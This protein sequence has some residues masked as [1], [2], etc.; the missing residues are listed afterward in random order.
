MILPT[1]PPEIKQQAEHQAAHCRVMGNPQR[2]MILWLLVERERTVTEIALAIGASLQ[3]ASHH[4]R[5]LE[6]SN[7]VK[8]RREHH[9]VFY[10][11]INNE[12]VKRCPVLINCPIVETQEVSLI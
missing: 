4:L 1:L 10:H 6:F 12:I 9:N 5:I 2:I 11:L 8:T 7:M 3:S